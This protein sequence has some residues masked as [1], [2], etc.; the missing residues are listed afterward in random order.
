VE[1]SL[2]VDV[3]KPRLFRG[4]ETTPNLKHLVRA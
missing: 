2:R 4:L 1:S 3:Q